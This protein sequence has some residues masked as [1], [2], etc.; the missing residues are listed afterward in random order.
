MAK[1]KKVT[2][3]L[4]TVKVIVM[5]PYSGFKKKEQK[6][7]LFWR[8]IEEVKKVDSKPLVVLNKDT[9]NKGMT[10]EFLRDERRKDIEIIETWSVDTCQMW[11]SGWGH[12]INERKNNKEIKRVVLLP[13]DIEEIEDALKFFKNVETFLTMGNIFDIII[14]DFHSGEKFAS[15]DLIDQ[16]GTYAL[17]ANWFPE[18]S[19][20]IF[21]LPLHKPR[22]E[23]TNINIDVLENMLIKRKFAY[24][25]TLNMLIQSWNFK[26]KKFDYKIKTVPLGTFKDQQD[27]RSFSGCLDQIERTE[28][29]LKLLWREK[30]VELKETDYQ[31]FIDT[32]EKL[33]RRST[34]IRENARIT[35]KNLLGIGL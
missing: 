16:Y 1:R 34:S 12:I 27:Y 30:N 14:G 28:R 22:S 25:Q 29:M 6:E 35:I 2:I 32:Y 3:E 8:L 19:K 9:K 21:R 15:K 5:F 10:K 20:S 13:G 26:K 31:E 33:D 17:L 24:E 11:L 23:F 4:N 7:I 18:V